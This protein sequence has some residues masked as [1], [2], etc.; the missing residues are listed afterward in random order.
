[1]NDEGAPR[2]IAELHDCLVQRVT[3]CFQMGCPVQ[4][5]QHSM[6]LIGMQAL[7]PGGNLESPKTFS[8]IVLGC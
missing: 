8:F 3:T 7:M 4:L 6:C 2:P 5:C 1:M